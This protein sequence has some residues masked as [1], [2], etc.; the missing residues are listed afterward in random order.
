MTQIIK[1]K[2]GSLRYGSGFY[3]STVP[4][5]F[6]RPAFVV[7]DRAG[8]E[9]SQ[10]RMTTFHMG[11]GYGNVKRIKAILERSVRGR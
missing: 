5:F 10:R 7:G 2:A 8:W 4:H 9:E 3:A 11:L 1:Q 6:N